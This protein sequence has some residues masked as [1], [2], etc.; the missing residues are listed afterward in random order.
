MRI[1]VF[2]GV[3]R[4]LERSVFPSMHLG[5]ID[6]SRTLTRGAG[7]G[8]IGLLFLLSLPAS[9]R[10]EEP[11]RLSLAALLEEV[12]AHNPGLQAAQERAAAMAAMPVQARAW[13]DPTLSYEAWNTPESFRL[14]RADNNIFRL[15]Q[16]IPF[17]GKRA[18]AGD[19]ATHEAA[20]SAH[21]AENVELEVVAAV[22]RAFAD[23][24]LA[25]ERLDV[26]TREKALVERLTHV[27]EERY[28]TNEATQ[29]D[30]LRSQV[31]LTHLVNQLQTERLAIDHARA[32]L[33]S[34]LSRD[35]ASLAGRPEALPVPALTLATED[36]IA[37][38]LAHRPDIRAQAETVAREQS[39]VK[40]AERNQYPDFEVSVGRF[41]NTDARD[42]FGAMLSM[43]LPIFNRAK[44]NAGIDEAG[45]RLRAAEAERERLKD[46]VRREVEQAYLRAKT[47][48]LQYELFTKTHIPQA[49]QALHVTESGYQTGE[50]PFLDLVDTL[51]SIESVHLEHVM[52]QAEFEK[53]L[54][55][56]EQAAGTA[57][58]QSSGRSQNPE[59]R[60]H[61]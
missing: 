37:Q 39:A 35:A 23:L 52:A 22:T 1:Q 54:A 51:R 49:E 40:L 29:A 6:L 25:Y 28:G 21:D 60:R 9:V 48:L 30:V 20:Q 24:W 15:S 44:Y 50:V 2:R 16:K 32:E 7:L 18:L 55:D 34:L 33:A 45:A 58:P 43:T 19:V 47:A 42:G 12:K 17:P 26:L 41:E 56:L 46:R 8:A 57:L 27:V 3:L 36:V 53:A 14:D 59:G 5:F 10:A 38:A 11:A 13:D 61:E 31:E 4:V